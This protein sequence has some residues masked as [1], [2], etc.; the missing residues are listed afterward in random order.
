MT[1]MSER[2]QR[3]DLSR[4]WML[5]PEVVFLNHGSFGATPTVVLEAQERIRHQL[6]SEPLRFFD[7][8]YQR[9]IDEARTN[10]P[11]RRR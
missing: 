4:H 9:E 2:P 5:D 7:R 3:S 10:W 11:F 1:S 8:H 6:E